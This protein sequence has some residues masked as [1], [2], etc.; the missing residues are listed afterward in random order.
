VAIRTE[1]QTSDLR[2]I[3]E[4]LDPALARIDTSDQ[5]RAYAAWARAAGD[6]V[7]ANARPRSFARGVLTVECASSI[8]AQELTYLGGQLLARMNE[9][10]AEHP[11]ERF[12]FVTRRSPAP[13]IDPSGQEEGVPAAKSARRDARIEPADLEAARAVAGTVGDERLRRTIET[14]LQAASPPSPPGAPGGPHVNPKK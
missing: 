14:A 12:R 4:I 3:S 6:T 2:K 5:G 11:V 8:W 13:S 9:L 1:A 10:D 7:A